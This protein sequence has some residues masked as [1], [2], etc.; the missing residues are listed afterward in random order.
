MNEAI[1]SWSEIERIVKVV[2]GEQD[3]SATDEFKT[4]DITKAREGNK[5]AI[6]R[7]RKAFQEIKKLSQAAREEAQDLKKA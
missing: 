3:A 2:S 7:V 6:T 1:K 5:L 4:G